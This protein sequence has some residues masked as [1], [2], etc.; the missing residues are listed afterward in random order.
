LVSA[1]TLN[2]GSVIDLNNDNYTPVFDKPAYV[3]N[4]FKNDRWRKYTEQLFVNTNSHIRPYYA[5]YLIRTYNSKHSLNPI[6]NLA[7][8]YM[9][10]RTPED[11]SQPVIEKVL[12]HETNV[13]K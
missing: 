3:L 2:S 12:L 8:F 5:D 9:L 10:E 7:I 1:A 13:H 6:A 11:G 4:R